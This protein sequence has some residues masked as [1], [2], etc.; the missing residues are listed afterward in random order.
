MDIVVLASARSRSRSNQ[1]QGD[2]GLMLAD[3]LFGRG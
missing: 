1:L 3:P 2:A